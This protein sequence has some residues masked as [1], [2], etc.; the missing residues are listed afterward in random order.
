MGGLLL[1]CVQP[2]C[3]QRCIWRVISLKLLYVSLSLSSLS[4]FIS[5]SPLSLYFSLS[6]L[7][8]FLSHL[9]LLFL[10][11]SLS[12]LLL[13]LSFFLFLCNWQTQGPKNAGHYPWKAG[14]LTRNLEKVSWLDCQIPNQTSLKLLWRRRDFTK[15]NWGIHLF[16]SRWNNQLLEHG[17]KLVY[18]CNP[19]TRNSNSDFHLRK[20]RSLKKRLGIDAAEQQKLTCDPFIVHGCT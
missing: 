2:P 3:N 20:S 13:S 10:S 1:S 12:L 16:N 5:L 6:S 19:C 14:C 15:R 17:L 8:L 11:F 18:I 9:S 7:P 4:L